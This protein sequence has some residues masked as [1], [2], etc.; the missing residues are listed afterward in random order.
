MLDE[1]D[2]R[3]KALEEE[4]KL[5]NTKATALLAVCLQQGFELHAIMTVLEEMSVSLPDAEDN[6]MASLA[7]EIEKARKYT[8]N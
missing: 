1:M 2:K 5:L 6:M 8:L 3:I 4:V 7:N